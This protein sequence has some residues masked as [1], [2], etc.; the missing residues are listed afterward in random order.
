MRASLTKQ[1]L[2]SSALS[3]TA[4]I[5]SKLLGLVSTLILA[6]I[7]TPEIFALAAMLSISL[8][9]LDVMADVASETYILQK[10]RLSS[11]DIGTAWTFNL[12]TKVTIAGVL[13]LSAPLF[14]AFFRQ[15]LLTLP[16]QAIALVLPLRALQSPIIFKCKRHLRYTPLVWQ[17]FAERLCAVIVVVT[18]AWWTQS[19]WAF[20][21]A[22][23]VSTAL[24]VVISY[25]WGKRAPRFTLTQARSQWQ[26]SRWLIGKQV[27]GYLRSQL[28]TALVARYFPLAVTGQF[29]VARDLAMA[30][31]RYLLGPA[32][33]PLLAT[34]RMSGQQ[35]GDL[36]DNTVLS[37]V[38]LLLITVP[39]CIFVAINAGLLVLVL[40]GDKWQAASGMLAY[41][42]FLSFYWVFLLV[43]EKALMVKGKVRFLFYFDLMALLLIAVSLTGVIQLSEP[44]NIHLFILVRVFTGFLLTGFAVGI[45]FH[46]HYEKLLP[47]AGVIVI[48]LVVSTL[49]VYLNLWIASAVEA[50]PALAQLVLLGISFIALYS[51]LIIPYALLGTP[52]PIRYRLRFLVTEILKRKTLP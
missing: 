20:V 40:L 16:L 31:G 8:Y 37:Y 17:T 25:V 30:P 12:L 14:S 11:G 10:R 3:S 35:E 43:T 13:I 4:Q 51:V 52:K 26:F 42:I 46:K 38:L 33:E 24:G 45:L 27:A 47:V 2:S 9:F 41:M 6:R 23:L 22:D 48:C 19:I 32:I 15:E 21:L 39:L 1:T 49:S 34:F 28:D 7:L 36:L 29:H 5:V 44:L 18:V 50:W